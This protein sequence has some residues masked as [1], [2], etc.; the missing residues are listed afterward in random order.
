MLDSYRFAK[1]TLGPGA[2][3][4]DTDLYLHRRQE[5]CPSANVHFHSKT[6]AATDLSC[7]T[8]QRSHNISIRAKHITREIHTHRASPSLLIR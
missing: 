3:M 4:E 1:T 5:A 2:M 6:I 8:N 7:S